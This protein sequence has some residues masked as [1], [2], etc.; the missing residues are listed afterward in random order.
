ML[1]DVIEAAE[2]ICHVKMLSE[3]LAN[4][5]SD[6]SKCDVCRDLSSEDGNEIVFCDKC[7]I[8]VHQL[9]YGIR[10]IP[11]DHWFCKRCEL[12]LD[13]NIKCDLCPFKGGAMKP[14]KDSIDWA[15][16]SCALWIPAIMFE[17]PV[18]MELITGRNAIP[19][20]A[21]VSLC[22][23]CRIPQG[24]T[25]KCCINGCKGRFHVTCAY[26]Q[27]LVMD[28]HSVDAHVRFFAFCRKHSAPDFQDK[29]KRM[30]K[31]H[32]MPTFET[33]LNQDLSN[34]P[35][36][37]PSNDKSNFLR[38]NSPA[39]RFHEHVTVEDVDNLL[40]EQLQSKRGFSKHSPNEGLSSSFSENTYSIPG[41]IIKLILAYWR[42]KRRSEFNSPLVHK[43][44]P[45]W[46]VD[47]NKTKKPETQQINDETMILDTVDQKCDYVRNSL[48]RARTMADMVIQRERRK[49]DLVQTMRSISDVQ[50]DS[51]VQDPIGATMDEVISTA[52][53]YEPESDRRFISTLSRRRRGCTRKVITKFVTGNE[54]VDS[55]PREELTFCE[56]A[57]AMIKEGFARKRGRPRT[58]PVSE[59][60]TSKWFSYQ[61]DNG[62]FLVPRMPIRRRGRPRRVLTSVESNAEGKESILSARDNSVEIVSVNVPMEIVDLT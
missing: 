50:L 45:H 7:N 18:N 28:I 40:T 30:A 21:R 52:H 14:F 24:I 34:A 4:G 5:I 59:M 17:D 20:E 19:L 61:V 26:D 1:E 10:K 13:L 8:G 31:R 62:D 51:V 42:I 46:T 16:V 22:D 2:Q 48:K 39:A 47:L 9:C 12:G 37:S 25:I 35:R 3:A 38:L 54:V 44:P 15:H 27:G 58:R 57:V 49:T 29:F 56:K 33:E 41:D 53:L 60:P 11:E 32:K 6:E 55:I 43:P 36:P 23:L